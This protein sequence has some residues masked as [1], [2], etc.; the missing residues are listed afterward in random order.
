MAQPAWLKKYLTMKPE[1]V[2]IFDDL[3][4]WQD[5]CRFELIDFNPAHLYKSNEYKEWSR[6][7]SFKYKKNNRF[8]KYNEKTQ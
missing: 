1:V 5:H 2:K 3:D 6:K 8:S 4:A 7:K